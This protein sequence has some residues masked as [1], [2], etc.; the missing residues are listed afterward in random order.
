MAGDARHGEAS[1]HGLDGHL[2]ADRAPRPPGVTVRQDC[3]LRSAPKVLQGDGKGIPLA[4]DD[5]PWCDLLA[6]GSSVDSNI[7]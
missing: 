6:S 4:N 3:S 7:K 1:G 2:A 5:Y